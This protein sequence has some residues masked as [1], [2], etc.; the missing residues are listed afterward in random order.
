MLRFE[1]DSAGAA[2]AVKTSPTAEAQL[3]KFIARFSSEIAALGTACV[4]RMRA[5]LPGAVVL[6]YD[7]YNALV[8]GFGP[9]ERASEA[10]FSIAFYPRRI[11]LCLLQAGRAKLKNP[12]KLLHGAGRLNRFIPLTSAGMLDDPAVNNLMQ[13][14]LMAAAVAIP[15]GPDGYM[16][17]KSVSATQRPRK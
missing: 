3:S 13:Q 14:A 17:I 9:S 10:I 16:V 2:P 8:V 1:E 11:S 5:K 15:Q 4:Q 7:N 12:E 6:V